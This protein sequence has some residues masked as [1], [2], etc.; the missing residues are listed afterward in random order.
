LFNLIFHLFPEAIVQRVPAFAFERRQ[1]RRHSLEEEEISNDPPYS[2]QTL[3]I[4]DRLAR[5]QQK[6]GG[7]WR[8]SNSNSAPP[9]R[10]SPKSHQKS[11]FKG[12]KPFL[13][14]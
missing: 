14:N 11:Y 9:H 6:S 10:P 12:I 13:Q 5:Q 2:I 1:Y 3:N 4:Q 7:V 8:K